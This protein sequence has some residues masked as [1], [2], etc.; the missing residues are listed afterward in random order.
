MY[1][2]S[3]TDQLSARDWLKQGL[4]TLTTSGF[5]ALKAEPLA[6]AMGVSRGS[7]YWHFADV[8]AFHAAL[9]D[10]W[11]EVAAER[12]I[13]SLET[14]GRSEDALRRLIRTAFDARL[15]TEAA[16]R[17]WAMH[18]PLARKA[19]D[20]IDRRRV[21]YIA[22]LLAKAGLPLAQARARA[23]ILYWAFVGFALSDQP[24]ARQQQQDA[25]TELIR[26]T[27]PQD[28]RQPRKV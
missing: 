9:L 7:F 23:R 4:K 10:Y 27:V 3:M 13:A 17:G 15:A 21:S 20:A 1:G 2:D 22:G 6:K 16:I 25:I 28:R 26:I 5:M 18:E 14:E 8:A 19:M 12:V 24:L 11:R